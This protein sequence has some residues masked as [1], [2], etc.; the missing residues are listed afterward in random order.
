MWGHFGV[1]PTCQAAGGGRLA[2]SARWRLGCCLYSAEGVGG[3]RRPRLCFGG[4]AGRSDA[5]PLFDALL[6]GLLSCWERG[7]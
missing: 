3:L 4:G 1:G 2:L 7:L 5:A 6:I